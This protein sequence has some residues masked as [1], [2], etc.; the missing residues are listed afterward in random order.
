M[1]FKELF[2]YPCSIKKA[3]TKLIGFKVS[4]NTH[5]TIRKAHA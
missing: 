2:F 1:G 4:P 5:P 3:W